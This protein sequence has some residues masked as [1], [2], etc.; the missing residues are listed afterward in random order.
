[1]RGEINKLLTGGKYDP[2]VAID[3]CMKLARIAEG[4]ISPSSPPAETLKR[5]IDAPIPVI[6]RFHNEK[7]AQEE[8]VRVERDFGKLRREQTGRKGLLNFVRYFWH[9]LEPKNRP[10]VEG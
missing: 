5:L 8:Q 10:L 1:V 4:Y 2:V 9:S 6:D 3:W 7:R